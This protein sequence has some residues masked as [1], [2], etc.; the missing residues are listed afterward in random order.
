[1]PTVKLGAS[2][3]IVIPKKLYDEL[4]L[5]AGDYLEVELYEGGRLIVTPKD[6]VDR[7]PEIDT[8]LREAEEDVTAGRVHGP[9][10]TATEAVKA[11]RSASRRKK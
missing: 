4:G 10:K 2:R 9:F 1:M 7:H 11:L 3:Q 5:A 8:R 6:L